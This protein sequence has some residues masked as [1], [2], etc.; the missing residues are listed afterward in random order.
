MISNEQAQEF[1]AGWIAA[2]NAHDIDAI[3]SHYEDDFSLRSPF[4]AKM[5]GD[6]S[7]CLTGKK[8]IG[9]YWKKGLSLLP[10]L[11]FEVEKVLVGA[12]SIAILYKGPMGVVA[13]TFCIGHSGRASSAMAHYAQGYPDRDGNKAT[14][15][16]SNSPEGRGGNKQ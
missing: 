1:A 10:D 4:I 13:E 14:D 11:H 9:A 8:A 6:P 2:W 7:G 16:P 12:D 15:N 5:P 3:L